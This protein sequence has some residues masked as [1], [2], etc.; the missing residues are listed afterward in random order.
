MSNIG[1]NNGTDA[2]FEKIKLGPASK[3]MYN[4]MKYLKIGSVLAATIVLIYAS[5]LAIIVGMKAI[6]G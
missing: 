6:V 5:S 3:F 4:F 1:Y 2:L